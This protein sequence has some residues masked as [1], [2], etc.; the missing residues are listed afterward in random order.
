[1]VTVMQTSNNKN[2]KFMWHFPYLILLALLTISNTCNAGT[3]LVYSIDFSSQADADALPWLEKKGY[4]FK[5]DANDI[6][7][8]FKNLQLHFATT[9][10]KAGIFGLKLSPENYL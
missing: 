10:Q 1:M 2:A 4:I 9:K 6:D 3:A 8:T 5:L 7:V